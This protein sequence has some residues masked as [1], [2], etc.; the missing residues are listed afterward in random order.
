MASRDFT[1]AS[2][3][4]HFALYI[5]HVIHCQSELPR[6]PPA[7]IQDY[8]YIQITVLLLYMQTFLLLHNYK[9]LN[10]FFQLPVF[11]MEAVNAGDEKV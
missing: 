9:C 5:Y 7:Q 8:G 1:A 3:H 6:N 10:F 11:S 4:V 2:E